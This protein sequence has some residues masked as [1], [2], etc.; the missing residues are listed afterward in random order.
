MPTH[1]L[2]ASFGVLFSLV[3]AA[4]PAAI[5]QIHGRVVTIDAKHGTFEIHHDPFPAM[6]MAMTMPVQ[7]KNGADLK[8]LHVGEVINATIDTSA[9][10]WSAWNIRPASPAV[11]PR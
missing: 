9:V 11:K 1:F 4:S 7:P 6:P 2:G 3:V 10:P 5:E 8:K